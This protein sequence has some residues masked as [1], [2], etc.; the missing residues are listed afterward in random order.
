MDKDFTTELP[1]MKWRILD[2]DKAKE[3]KLQ[4][5]NLNEDIALLQINLDDIPRGVSIDD[6]ITTIINEGI[7]IFDKR[8]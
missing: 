8:E 2:Y 1:K 6:W 5:L 4:V 3:M 7:A